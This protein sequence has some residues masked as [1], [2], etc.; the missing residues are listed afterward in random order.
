MSGVARAFCMA[1]FVAFFMGFFFGT[2]IF[3]AFFVVFFLEI[4]RAFFMVPVYFMV[5]VPVPYLFFV[6]FLCFFQQK[7]C[8]SIL[9]YFGKP[10]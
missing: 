4:F 10:C 2:G 5:S 1:F 7:H 9:L 3:M 8:L 6:T